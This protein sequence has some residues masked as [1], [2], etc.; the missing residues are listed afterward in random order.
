MT[1]KTHVTAGALFSSIFMLFTGDTH[2]ILGMLSAAF[3]SLLPDIDHEKSWIGRRLWPI[4]IIVTS[5]FSHRTYTHSIQ[6]LITFSVLTAGVLAAFNA[7]KIYLAYFI[8]GYISHLWADS[9]T[10]SRVR[11]DYESN[12]KYGRGIVKTGS[13]KEFLIMG[14]MVIATALIM[15]AVFSIH[16]PAQ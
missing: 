5:I 7:P 12:K 15:S 2:L 10:V 11:M 8:L 14:V 9:L 3:G 4:S 1:Y 13:A 6:G 16:M